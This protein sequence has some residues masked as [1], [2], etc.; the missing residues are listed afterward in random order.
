MYYEIKCDRTG[1]IIASRAR[2]A[3]AP[4]TRMRGLLGRKSLPFGEGIILRPASSIHTLFMRFAIDVIYLDA[5]DRVIK[6]VPNLV[7]YRFS[8]APKA[9]TTVELASGALSG[10]HLEPGTLLRFC[11]IQDDEPGDARNTWTASEV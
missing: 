2:M 11:A 9:R 3:S 6:T 8:S 10:L 5:A 1:E 4:L 7:P